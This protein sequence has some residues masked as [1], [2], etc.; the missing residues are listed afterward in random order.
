MRIDTKFDIRDRVIINGETSTVATVQRVFISSVGVIYEV[1][2]FDM[3]GSFHEHGMYEW[4]L[5]RAI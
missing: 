3:N 4:Q 5:E 1:S 2:W